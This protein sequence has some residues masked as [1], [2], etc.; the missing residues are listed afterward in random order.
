MNNYITLDGYKYMTLH[1]EWVPV[2]KKPNT[3]RL[4]LSG[5]TDVSYGPA[6]PKEWKGKIIAPI[7]VD[8]G[9]GSVDNLRATFAKR[10]G[11]SFTDHYAGGAVTVH[12]IGDFPEESL[13]A[14]WDGAENEFRIPVRM[15]MA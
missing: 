7:T 9:W 4:L 6:A 13:T 3:V 11:L 15:V 14:M 1:G 5:A 12:I 10:Q 8:A 2:R